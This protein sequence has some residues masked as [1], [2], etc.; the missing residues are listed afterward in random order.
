MGRRGSESMIQSHTP[1]WVFPLQ[2]S[3]NQCNQTSS[4]QC[5]CSSA[6][7]VY[8]SMRG[9]DGLTM[10]MT[11]FNERSFTPSFS[12]QSLVLI[13]TVLELIN[14]RRWIDSPVSFCLFLKKSCPN[15]SLWYINS[16]SWSI[17]TGSVVSR[18]TSSKCYPQHYVS[19]ASVS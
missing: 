3:R 12:A 16:K 18:A 17:S 15:S 1:R 14:P 2:S 19:F 11:Y 7:H 4:G 9:E 8:A 10:C 13:S 6:Q 5:N